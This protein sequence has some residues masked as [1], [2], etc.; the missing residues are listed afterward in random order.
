MRKQ[1]LFSGL[2]RTPQGD[3]LSSA[4]ALQNNTARYDSYQV[5]TTVA[6]PAVIPFF[7][8]PIGAIG[9]GFAVAKT[10]NDTNMKLARKL[11]NPTSMTIRRIVVSVIP[12]GSVADENETSD[13]IKN[14]LE[15]SIVE[16]YV[17]DT[18]FFRE[19]LIA[20]G[21]TGITGVC[22][23]DTNSNG[24]ISASPSIAGRED[25]SP[26][27]SIRS[28]EMFKVEIIPNTSNPLL[29][30]ALAANTNLY[31]RVYLEGSITRPID[32]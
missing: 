32:A 25:I 30:D 23:N 15:D 16:M 14:L 3:V 7:Q 2:V 13:L 4:Q 1:Q 6:I 5:L 11:E 12:F 8:V 31:F 22:A 26:A 18:L 9:S 28:R 24:A 10:L 20:C 27:I 29:N 17:S 19:H 21:G